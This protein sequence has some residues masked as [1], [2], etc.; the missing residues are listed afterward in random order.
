[1]STPES[2]DFGGMLRTARERQGLTIKQL[3]ETTKISQSVLTAL[4]TNEVNQVPGGLFIRA[5]VRSYAAEVGLDPEH[6][7]AVLLEA[8][9]DQ[10]YDAFIGRREESVGAFRILKELS[11]AGTAIGLLIISAIVVGLLLFFGLKD[12]IDENPDDDAVTVDDVVTETM[13]PPAEIRTPRRPVDRELVTATSSPISDVAAEEPLTVAVYPTAPCWV[14][15]RIDGERVFAGVMGAG[16][17]Q[18]YEADSQIVLN[19]G[20]AGAFSFSINEQPGRILG[21]PGQV[22]TVEIDRKN[23]RNFVRP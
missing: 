3:A 15:L 9:P 4:E 14:L 7:V 5:F 22:V 20:D 19:V 16:E 2:I 11:P 10:G 23:Y 6:I 13:S 12:S 17:R 8:H 18:V 1:M 21:G